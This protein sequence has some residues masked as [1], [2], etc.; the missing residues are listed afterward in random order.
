M[1]V[2]LYYPDIPF[3]DGGRAGPSREEVVEEPTTTFLN[4]NIY[5]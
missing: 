4:K 1:F 5:F 3:C 2:A